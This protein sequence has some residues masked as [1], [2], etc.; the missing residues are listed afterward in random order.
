VHKSIQLKLLLVVRSTNF[1]NSTLCPYLRGNFEH[2]LLICT[3]IC[4]F[5]QIMIHGQMAKLKILVWLNSFLFICT[6]FD[7]TITFSFSSNFNWTFFV[8]I[9]I[10]KYMFNG[11]NQLNEPNSTRIIK[12]VLHVLKKPSTWILVWLNN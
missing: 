1:T 5:I 9:P 4:S 3:K 11:A 10:I 7:F 2:F 8:R 12:N 6:D